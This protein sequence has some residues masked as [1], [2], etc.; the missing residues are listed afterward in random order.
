MSI[1]CSSLKPSFVIITKL[2]CLIYFIFSNPGQFISYYATVL[3]VGIFNFYLLDATDKVKYVLGKVF[4][5][6]P[7]LNFMRV[8]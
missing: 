3:G 7:Q 2:F 8:L 1:T 5:A 6:S 4:I